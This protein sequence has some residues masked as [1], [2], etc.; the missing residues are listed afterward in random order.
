MPKGCKNNHRSR[1]GSTNTTIVLQ[2]RLLRH[3]GTP[4]TLSTYI[5]RRARVLPTVLPASCCHKPMAQT[6]MGCK[7]SAG[8]EVGSTNTTSV[9]QLRLLPQ[10]ILITLRARTLFYTLVPFPTLMLSW[11]LIKHI[12]STIMYL[13]VYVLRTFLPS[14]P[15]RSRNTD[16]KVKLPPGC[17]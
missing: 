3:G 8:V 5:K 13:C 1:G 16:P 17:P 2:L 14:L 10:Q 7:I 9:L 4:T 12:P 15:R 11:V 6:S